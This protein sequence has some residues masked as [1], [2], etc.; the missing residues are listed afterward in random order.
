MHAWS[1]IEHQL[2][3]EGTPAEEIQ[4]QDHAVDQSTTCLESIMLSSLHEIVLYS[5]VG[6]FLAHNLQPYHR[7]F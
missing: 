5:T 6:V 3:A 2:T 1:C 4:L 7:F